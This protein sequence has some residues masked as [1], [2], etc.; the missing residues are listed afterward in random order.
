M[1]QAGGRRTTTRGPSRWRRGRRAVEGVLWSG[2]AVGLNAFS[3]AKGGDAQ[4]VGFAKSTPESYPCWKISS[5]AKAAR[6][7]A[8]VIELPRQSDGQGFYLHFTGGFRAANVA[9]GAW[10]I[11]PVL[12]NNKPCATGPFTMGQLQSFAKQN[13]FRAIAFHRFGWIDGKYYSSWVPI[14]PGKTNHSKG[15]SELWS[16]IAGN[17]ARLRT[18]KF[19]ETVEHP[20]KAEI[21]KA[22]DDKDPVEALARY[23]SLSLRSMDISVEQIANYYYEQLVNHMA[24]GQFEGERSTNSQAYTLYA[25]IHSF[26]LHL[27]AAQ[28]YLGA[29]VAYR[30]GLPESVDSIVG[31]VQKLRQGNLPR[32]ALL[33]LLISSGNVA[34]DPLK[35]G[36]FRRAGW[37]QEVASIRRILV[38]KRPY[39]SKFNETKGWTVPSQKQDGLFR[40]FRPLEI[41]GTAEK[42]VFD[43]LH[44]HY[45][46]CTDLLQRT[47]KA[48]GND[49][50]MTRITDEDIISLEVRNS[51]EPDS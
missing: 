40:Y 29:L 7:M 33:D 2:S 19:F 27:G 41:D 26:F 12:V 31:L 34:L 38:H 30:I 49:T 11:E 18:K 50:A 51:T 21:A 16:N 46:N 20:T 36:Q 13:D 39:G 43:I 28:D 17:I 47:A 42:D 4:G 14:I 44:H 32:D 48:S 37:M 10:R 15:T 5:I 35:S 24:A 6:D 9:N 45:E 3:T 1:R 25:H 8:Q 22:L 23:I